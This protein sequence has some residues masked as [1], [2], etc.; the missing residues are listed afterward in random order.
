M[1]A[2]YLVTNY[3]AALALGVVLLGGCAP[4]EGRETAGQYGGDV[5]IS[6]EIRGD[7]IKD[8][9]LKAF[10]IHVDTMQ[11]VVQ[12]SGFVDSLP[13]KEEAGRIAES[14]EGVRQVDNNIIVRSPSEG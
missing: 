14:V 6:T 4:I 13:Q 1:R 3:G 7:L 2:G 8:Q 11:G 9:A 5:K 10:Q 12:L